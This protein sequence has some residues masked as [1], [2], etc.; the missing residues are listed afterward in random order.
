MEEGR[1]KLVGK[2]WVSKGCRGWDSNP[3]PS[4]YE[5]LALTNLSYPDGILIVRIFRYSTIKIFYATLHIMW[6]NLLAV[7]SIFWALSGVYLI[8]SFGVAII[9]WSWKQFLVALL[10]FVFLSVAEIA[11]AAIAEP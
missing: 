5:T 11:L 7:N 10:V 6:G 9:T 4:A 2:P 8:Y 1:A 3:R